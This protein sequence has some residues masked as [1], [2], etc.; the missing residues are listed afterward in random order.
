MADT[1]WKFTA[2]G[3]IP[4]G[5]QADFEEPAPPI[6]WDFG[7]DWNAGAAQLPGVS[8]WQAGAAQVPGLREIVAPP[9]RPV[10]GQAVGG[11]AMLPLT[12]SLAPGAGAIGASGPSATGAPGTET[13]SDAASTMPPAAAIEGP[14][15][16]AAPE[17]PPGLSIEDAMMIVRAGQGGGPTVNRQ[18]QAALAGIRSRRDA[19]VRAQAER[20]LAFGDEVAAAGENVRKL[21]EQQD[22]WLT[23]H[24]A[25]TAQKNAEFKQQAE[26]R[27]ARVEAMSQEAKQAWQD[28]DPN[29]IMRGG[30]GVMFGIAAALGAFGAALTR[31]PNSVAQ[32]IEAALDRDLEAQKSGARGKQEAASF[33]KEIHDGF[34]REGQGDAEARAN[35]E[36]LMMRHFA[37]KTAALAQT[38]ASAEAK[39]AGQRQATALYEQA[40]AKLE[41]AAKL[42]AAPK[43][44]KRLTPQEMA[45]QALK[46]QKMSLENQKLAGDLAKKKDEEPKLEDAPAHRMQ[47]RFGSL[48]NGLNII[49]DINEYEDQ[50]NDS[51]PDTRGVGDIVR[52]G[53]QEIKKRVTGGTG[54]TPLEDRIAAGVT[55]FALQSYREQTNSA[56]DKDKEAALALRM[57]GN[58]TLGASRE[59][60][61]RAMEQNI[62]ANQLQITA[63]PEGRQKQ[64]YQSQLDEARRQL[65]AATRGRA[66]DP[67]AGEG[68]VEYLQREAGKLGNTVMGN[69]PVPGNIRTPGAPATPAGGTSVDPAAVRARFGSGGR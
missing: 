16:E 52:T 43:G 49:K 15:M 39:L 10:G 59:N 58:G 61:R 44:G 51:M 30:R 36:A 68:F 17:A 55:G 37:V 2:G 54:M 26:T 6:R 22:Q 33:A 18:A 47:D 64:L 65:D 53:K 24:A 25:E 41:E 29:R 9:A 1:R 62:A 5:V 45:E 32:S 14:S 21:Y 19:N 13:T 35:T 11:G 46:L 63:M 8:E 12:S 38:Q 56:P 69:A 7:G 60:M 42:A 27:R 57:R 4:G 48:R 40:D 3:G 28:I 50:G 34:L 23:Q 67:G 66:A 20:E 31:T